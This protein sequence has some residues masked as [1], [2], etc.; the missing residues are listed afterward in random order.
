MQGLPGAFADSAP[1]RWGRNLI[2]KRLRTLDQQAGRTPRA[3][4]DVDFLLGVS[5]LTR[6][7]ALRYADRPG[8]PFRA[9]DNEVPRLVELPALNARC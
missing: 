3:L 9:A 6:Q 1:D 4:T 8:E 7:G 5:D 2:T